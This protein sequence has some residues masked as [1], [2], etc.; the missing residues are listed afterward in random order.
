MNDFQFQEVSAN[1]TDGPIIKNQDGTFNVSRSLNL[2]PSLADN[3]TMFQCVIKHPA[4]GTFQI[5]EFTLIVEGE[6]EGHCVCGG[7]TYNFSPWY[8]RGG[9]GGGHGGEKTWSGWAQCH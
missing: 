2:K 8:S 4:S 5:R 3:Q 9:T 7:L 1:V 6:Q